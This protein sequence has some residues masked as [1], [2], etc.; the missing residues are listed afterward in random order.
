MSGHS[1][2]S[3]VKHQKAT[4]DAAK[5]AAFTKASR[6]IT[7]AVREGG[8]TRPDDNFKLRLAVDNARAVNMPKDTIERAIERAKAGSDNLEPFL[9]E[10]YGPGGVA[11]LVIGVTDN[12]QRTAGL[13]KHIFNESGGTLAGPGSAIFLFNSNYQPKSPMVIAVDQKQAMSLF[14]DKLLSLDDVT[15]VYP[16]I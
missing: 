4:T 14:L 10:G 11:M 15:D 12:K 6:A 7:M 8:G 3:K 9:Y 2:W 5:S 1:K 13:V 16:N